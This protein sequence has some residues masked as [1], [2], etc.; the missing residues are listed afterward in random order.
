MPSTEV[1]SPALT[2]EEWELLG[3]LLRRE[4]RNLPL[5][6]RHTDARSAREAIHQRLDKAETL[7]AKLRP[8]LEA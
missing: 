7:L 4:V 3:E 2:A 6:M 5:E 8:V 1:Q